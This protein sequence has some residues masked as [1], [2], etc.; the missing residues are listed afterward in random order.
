MQLGIGV[1]VS[2]SWATPSNQVRLVKLA[3]DLG[4]HSAWTFQRLIVPSPP[5][6]ERA[7]MAVYQSVQDPI[8]PLAFLAGQTGRIRLGTAI[9]NVPFVAPTVLAKQLATL[10]ILSGGRVDA[11]LGLGW[12][13]VEFR[14]T[15]ATFARRGARLEEYVGVLKAL[16]TQ[17]VIDHKGEF[18]EVPSSRM[19]PKPVQRPHPPILLGGMAEPALRRIGRIADGWIS[20][21]R[22]DLT[23]VEEAIAT[24][25]EAAAAAGRDPERLRS[26]IRGPIRV[27]PAGTPDRQPLTGTLEEIRA[28]LDTLRAKGVTEVFLDFNFDPEI[29]N[30]AADPSASMARAEEA[31]RALAP[32]ADG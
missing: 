2:G 26:V 12:S 7:R 16:M 11:G 8:V 9:V 14:S 4:Y 15:G 17:D 22:H 25:T 10:D 5:P 30:P 32:S 27:R 31:I 20:A 6:D 3:E 13:D 21:S 24:M 23:R 29:G 1:P 18:Y 19:E 28:D